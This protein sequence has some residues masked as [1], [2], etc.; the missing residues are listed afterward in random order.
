[1]ISRSLT[2]GSPNCSKNGYTLRENGKLYKVSNQSATHC[3]ASV[4]CNRDGARLTMLK[5]EEDETI[6]N[7]M[8]GINLLSFKE[9]H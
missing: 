1:M 5:T 6:F 7:N 8:R 3:E 4:A 9:R 2:A